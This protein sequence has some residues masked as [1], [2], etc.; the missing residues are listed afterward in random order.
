MYTNLILFIF[1]IFFVLK[2]VRI[3]IYMKGNKFYFYNRTELFC[4]VFDIE[5]K[6]TRHVTCK[7]SMPYNIEE[8]LIITL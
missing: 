1:T 6:Q 8:R 4:N 3:F 5:V 7:F 2:Y